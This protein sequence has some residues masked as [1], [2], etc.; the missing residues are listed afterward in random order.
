MPQA[1]R[2]LVPLDG[3]LYVL[4]GVGEGS[5]PRRLF[6][7]AD[8]RWAEVGTGPLL[9]PKISADGELVCFVWGD[10]ARRCART[11]RAGLGPA[12]LSS[13]T[14]QRVHHPE[15][16]HAP[17]SRRTDAADPARLPLPRR[18]CAAATCRRRRTLRSR[19]G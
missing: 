7:P 16:R 11:P 1:D 4:D 10:E 5:E 3:A 15:L 8:A 14:S 17:F 2:V 6:D 18:R 13:Y 19:A 12:A 9:D